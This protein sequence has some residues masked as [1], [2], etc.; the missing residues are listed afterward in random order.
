MDP[1]KRRHRTE[2]KVTG[3]KRSRLKP[4]QIGIQYIAEV[5]SPSCLFHDGRGEDR[6]QMSPTIPGSVKRQRALH[7]NMRQS[8]ADYCLS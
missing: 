6:D 2:E 4:Q 8:V 5:S 1:V 3:Y 7:L